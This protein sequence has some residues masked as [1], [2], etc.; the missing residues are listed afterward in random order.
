MHNQTCI[1]KFHLKSHFQ[2]MCRLYRER[3]SH[4]P[5]EN[6]TVTQNHHRELW[7]NSKIKA[8]LKFL[9]VQYSQGQSKVW[10]LESAASLHCCA[11]CFIYVLF[12]VGLSSNRVHMVRMRQCLSRRGLT[13][14]S[15][16]VVP[17]PC[18]RV[19]YSQI[20]PTLNCVPCSRY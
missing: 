9:S 15:E 1:S 19:L 10:N 18:P 4:W 2:E 8:G 7:R 20:Q 5:M 14:H 17:A 13:M 11:E 16:T 6:V 12:T 3:W